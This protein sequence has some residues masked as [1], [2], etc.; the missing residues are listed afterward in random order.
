VSQGG[1]ISRFRYNASATYETGPVG[2]S[3][4]EN[5]QKRYHDVASN[6]TEVPRY[7]SA[8]ETTDG[9]FFYT[10]SPSWKVALGAKN[11]FNRVPPYANYANTV[12]NFVG[13]YDLSYGNPLGRYVYLS[14]TYFMN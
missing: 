9:Q 5:F 12:N 4:I 3:L 1:V 14:A 7:V 8:Y 13:G 11:I 6:I 10:A 2:I